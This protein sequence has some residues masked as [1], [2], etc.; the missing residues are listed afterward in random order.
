MKPVLSVVVPVFNEELSIEASYVR[1]TEVLEGLD[2]SYELIFVNDGSKDRS[3]DLLRKIAVTDTRVSL[4]NFSR[5]FGHQMAITAGVDYAR[6]EAIVV[7]DADLQDPPEVIPL[8]VEKWRE[9]Y[10]VVYGQ[11]LSRQG[12]HFLKKTTAA[13]FYR[14]LKR[15]T[16]IDIPLDTGD[17]R[18][19][20]R[21]V[22]EVLRGLREQSRFVRGMVSWIGFRQIGIPFAR[23]ER[24]A[25]QTNYTLRKMLGLAVNGIVSFSSL[26]LRIASYVGV[27]VAFMG[28]ILGLY[29]I[30]L[31]VFTHATLVGWTSLLVAISFIGGVQL[32]VLGIIGEYISKIYDETRKRPLYVVAEVQGALAAASENEQPKKIFDRV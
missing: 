7:I 5:N 6:G 15:I 17:F 9:G 20:S 27:I 21:Q 3:A 14:L 31:K 16:E 19:I 29:G 30:F 24:F 2:D 23:Q 28:F 22:A 8:M 12:E 32:M 25:G 26:P 18:L 10:D 4:I 11:R 13:W 1:L